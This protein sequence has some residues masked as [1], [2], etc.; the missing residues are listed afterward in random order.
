MCLSW[1]G[2]CPIK[3]KI[4]TCMHFSLNELIVCKLLLLCWTCTPLVRPETA[5]PHRKV[6]WLIKGSSQRKVP[7]ILELE[8]SFLVVII[9]APAVVPPQCEGAW[10]NAEL[11]FY[12]VFHCF[13]N[14]VL[15]VLFLLLLFSIFKKPFFLPGLCC[16]YCCTVLLIYTVINKHNWT[17]YWIFDLSFCLNHSNSVIIFLHN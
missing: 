7:C 8:G 15:S 10:S 11:S 5:K 13:S 9:K 3:S 4:H 1:S 17:A 2:P 6:P 12:F 14:W 16:K